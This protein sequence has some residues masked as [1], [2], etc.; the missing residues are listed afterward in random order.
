MKYAGRQLRAV[1]RDFPGEPAW[2]P[3]ADAINAVLQSYAHS[4]WQLLLPEVQ[5]LLAQG[6]DPGDGARAVG[7]D[8]PEQGVAA[9]E[10]AT[11]RGE[12]APS[13]L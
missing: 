10:A 9:A 11:G 3:T 5:C 4:F 12:A 7:P 1:R 2:R 8:G 6:K 13:A